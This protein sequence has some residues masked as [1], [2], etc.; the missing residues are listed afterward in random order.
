MT[1]RPHDASRH[2]KAHSATSAGAECQHGTC[3][4]QPKKGK[5]AYLAAGRLGLGD[6]LGE[7]GSSASDS[8]SERPEADSGS[9]VA[10]RSRLTR[11]A[12]RRPCQGAAG[13]VGSSQTMLRICAGLCSCK[14]PTP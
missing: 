10:G 9:S 7:E 2:F 1:H 8:S 4:R 6:L 3:C 11:T 12:H 14:S 13:S 5:E